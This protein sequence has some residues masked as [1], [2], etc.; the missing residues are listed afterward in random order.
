MQRRQMFRLRCHSCE[1]TKPA[2]LGS[3]KTLLSA[4]EVLGSISGP[5]PAVSLVVKRTDYRYG[6]SGAWLPGWSNRQ[7]VASG[8]YKGGGREPTPLDDCRKNE[9]FLNFEKKLLFF[10]RNLP[11]LL[12]CFF[13]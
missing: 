1:L 11:K 10:V 12:S 9:T 8:V 2:S 6:R 7:S 13:C 4:R 5:V 3:P